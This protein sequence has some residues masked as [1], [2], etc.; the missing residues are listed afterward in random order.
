MKNYNKKYFFNAVDE[1]FC[2]CNILYNA[3]SIIKHDKEFD[4]YYNFGLRIDFIHTSK[5]F[6]EDELKFEADKKDYLKFKNMV[7]TYKDGVTANFTNKN[8]INY[9][10]NLDTSNFIKKFEKYRETKNKTSVP[11]NL[12]KF[13]VGFDTEYK[14]NLQYNARI[15]EADEL[16]KER[17]IILNKED[18]I[19]SYQLSFMISEDLYINT[20]ICV[21]LGF[22]LD[23]NEVIIKTIID[24]LNTV[25]TF[26]KNED[27]FDCTVIAHKNIVD[28]TKVRGMITPKV[29]DKNAEL[30]KKYE[31]L[32]SIRNCFVTVKPLAVYDIDYN[33]NYKSLGT[34]H[35]RDSLLL[36]NPQSLAYLG[37]SLNFKKLDVGENIEYMEDFIKYDP[38]AF[39]MY[40][41][42]DSNIVVNFL[43]S[44]YLH[45]LEDGKEVPLTIAGYSANVGQKFL[46]KLYNLKSDADFNKMFRGMDCRKIGKRK[47]Y[48]IRESL[49]RHFDI[50]AVNYYGGR[51]ETFVHGYLKGQ[52]YDIDGSKFYPVVASIIPLLDFNKDPT[53]IPAGEVKHD[54]FLWD[55]EEVGYVICDFDYAEVDNKMLP[56]ITVKAKKGNDD[57]G[58]IF[59]RS[60]KDVFTTLTEVKSAYKLGAKI[61]IKY[62]VKFEILDIQDC[63]TYPFLE[64]FKYFAKQRNK[65]KKGTQ[66][67][68]LWKLIA[69]S[70]TGKIG[71]GIKGK[72]VYDFSSAEMDDIPQSK[73]SC[74]PYITELTSVGRTVITEVMNC[75]ILE[76]WEIMNVVTDGFLARSPNNKIVTPEDINNIIEKYK[77]DDRFPTLNRWTEAVKSL[78][79]KSYLEIK[80]TGTDLLVVKTRVCA[81]L[82]IENEELSQYATTGFTNPPEWSDYSLNEQIKAFFKIVTDREK[83]FKITTKK[84]ITSRDVR[85]G[86]FT[87]KMIDKEISFNFDYKRKPTEIKME[88]DYICI[89]TKAWEN[90]EEFFIEKD[91][92]ERNKD[93]QI[94]DLQGDKK[95]EILEDLRKYKFRNIDKKN[96]F[97]DL[98]EKFFIAFFK[99]KIFTIT[100]INK[101]LDYI[102]LHKLLQLKQIALHLDITAYKKLKLQKFIK[103]NLEELKFEMLVLANKIFEEEKI[104][105]S[106]FG[107]ENNLI[108]YNKIFFEDNIKNN[109]NKKIN[110]DDTEHL[111]NLT[112]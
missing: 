90:I 108:K 38:N 25:G 11:Y 93:I 85:T 27:K 32:T 65:Y 71:Q 73:V 101:E 13:F 48:Y 45:C 78:E 104:R 3:E 4:V 109:K 55:V 34:I 17:N 75:F 112:I 31:S 79:E 103:D 29:F 70:F 2:N 23:F 26:I 41:A 81:L 99:T 53:Y 47:Q 36:D 51:N 56:C 84:L 89:K 19:I 82:N 24:F 110:I 58:L 106:F 35:Y 16:E 49:Y 59:T 60:G 54:T 30:P 83:R 52:F 72:R 64:L 6:F 7:G 69:N 86:K 111:K 80:H 67:N 92:R 28:F 76:G 20:V 88:N 57:K 96:E 37:E 63:E 91:Y 68:K 102:Y 14:S 94:K 100:G 95:M 44:M 33:R 21:Y 15:N 18:E 62:G 87:G 46:K 43:Y 8:V 39:L 1:K 9:L 61:N 50:L 22:E 5:D 77:N 74:P 107:N 98:I 12:Y 105:F 66:L 97:N 42:Q 10:K 40:A